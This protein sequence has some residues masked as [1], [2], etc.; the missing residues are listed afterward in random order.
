MTSGR[1]IRLAGS[2]HSILAMMSFSRGETAG[3]LGNETGW[4]RITL[5]RPIMLACLKGTVPASKSKHVV[6]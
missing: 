1:L 3:L 5:Y 4:V 2:L 6:G